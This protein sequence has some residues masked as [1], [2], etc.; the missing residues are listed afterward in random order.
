MTTENQIKPRFEFRA[1]GHHLEELINKM[2]QLS[3]VERI[4]DIYEV[5]LMSAGNIKN[6]VKIRNKMMDIKV[7]LSE[8]K[9]LELW[10]PYLVGEFPMKASI[11]R[12]EVFPAFGVESPPFERD[13]Y[14][15]VQF[16]DELISPDPDIIAVYTQKKRYAYTINNCICEV[17]EV[18][19]NGALIKTIA[20]ESEDLKDILDTKTLIG[21]N[22]QEENVNYPLAIK[23]VIGLFPRPMDHLHLTKN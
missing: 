15:L 12:S 2:N 5:Y 13:V 22:E 21:F 10:E 20:V 19:I 1:F 14:T 8:K 9:S 23:R 18:I 6:N 3:K 11:I 7:L 4:R 17:A 16:L